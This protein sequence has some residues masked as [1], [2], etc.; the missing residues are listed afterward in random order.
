MDII[1]NTN[2]IFI[3]DLD[4]TL[5]GDCV[6][7]CE[8]YK[9]YLI[10]NKLGIKIKI[11]EILE[12]HYTE[13]SK[14]I[15]PYFT[16]FINKMREYFP[17]SYFYIYTASE[18]K[19][20]EKEISIIEKNLNIKFDRPIFTRTHCSTVIK[21]DKMIYMKSIELIKKKI[22]INNAEIIIID[23]NEVYIDNTNKLIKCKI[24]NY[25]LFNNYWD[26]IPINKI[27]NK[28]FIK[29]LS[30][31]I[32]LGR[33][34][35]SYKINTTKQKIGYYKWLYEKCCNVNNNNKKYKEDK[36]WLN[37]TKIIIDN[38]IK[39]FNDTSINFIKNSLK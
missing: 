3:I 12:E 38:K 30:S 34:N 26:Y 7:Q 19:W 18:K 32:E 25:K 13:K 4:G 31:L 29:Y 22:K 20:A 24:Y 1:N 27:N 15:R 11:N 37:L 2:Y 16:Y 8:I 9:I 5:I 10:L 21:D 6:Y 35:P 28:I 39:I 33:L 23:D 36:F 17:N 14:L